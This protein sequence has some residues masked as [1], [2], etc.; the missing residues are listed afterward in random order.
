LAGPPHPPK[1]VQQRQRRGGV[2]GPLILIFI[3][4]VF[5][6]ENTGYLPPNTW[7]NLWRLWPLAL[8]L[9]GV[10][11]LFAHRIPWL[12]LAALAVMVM[13]VGVV[14]TT[15][16]ASTAA[17]SGLAP[18]TAETPLGGATQ[19]TVAVR[20]GAGQLSIGPLADSAASDLAMMS[21]DGP[22][23]L[24]LVPS[25]TATTGGTGQ[26]EYQL[27]SHSTPG[28]IPFVGGRSD[29]T[30]LDVNLNPNVPIT[31]LTVQTGATDAH[32]DLSALKVNN[33]EMSVGAAATWMRLPQVDG[34]TTAHISGGASTITLEIPRGV[35][36]QLRHRGGLSNLSVDQSR[37][38]SVGGGVYRSP[39][40]DTAQKRID[41][42]LETG[43]TTIQVS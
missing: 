28:F 7:L 19:A 39:D 13:V 27:D 25:Y 34:T 18:R 4:S 35:A 10:E 22:P 2:V 11:L 3:G 16:G 26:L 29:T 36:L 33:I 32:L 24:S 20:F 43:L 30:R 9:G 38:P 21:Y 6:L 37:F 40:Y 15:F 31:L 17:S 23:E 14:V 1:P 41:L 12:L 42:N 5:L 8:V